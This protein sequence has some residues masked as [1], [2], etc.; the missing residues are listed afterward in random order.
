MV[1]QIGYPRLSAVIELRGRGVEPWFIW[2][3]LFVWLKGMRVGEEAT[4]WTGV[5]ADTF[6]PIIK[7][8]DECLKLADRFAKT[9][10][11]FTTKKLTFHQFPSHWNWRLKTSNQWAILRIMLMNKSKKLFLRVLLI[12][13]MLWVQSDTAI[14]NDR[15]Y[16]SGWDIVFGSLRAYTVTVRKRVYAPRWSTPKEPSSINSLS[17]HDCTYPYR[18]AR[19]CTGQYRS[20]CIGSSVA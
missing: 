16:Q 11:R 19:N 9:S 5:C 20:C 6:D 4:T 8:I 1:L 17:Y 10:F 7:Y 2:V 14:H 3:V 13:Y 18:Y 12:M 15:S